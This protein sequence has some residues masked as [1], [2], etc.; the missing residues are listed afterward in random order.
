[1]LYPAHP[2]WRHTAVC[3]PKKYLS[4]KLFYRNL[5]SFSL[6]P[7]SCFF[8]YSN[9]AVKKKKK[10]SLQSS[11]NLLTFIYIPFQYSE[12]SCFGITVHRPSLSRIWEKQVFFF[13]L[14]QSGTFPCVV[15]FKKASSLNHLYIIFG[16][17]IFIRY[18]CTCENGIFFLIKKTQ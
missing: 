15:R 9:I 14:D 11:K 7:M 6:S 16:S 10:R 17:H 13:R 8:Y 4:D 1:M 5:F 12:L 3:V 2:K 18:V